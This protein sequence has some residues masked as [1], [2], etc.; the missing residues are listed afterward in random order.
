LCKGVK[1]ASIFFSK[2][3]FLVS[4]TMVSRLS[5][6]SFV[7][8]TYPA[9]SNRSIIPVNT[10]VTRVKKIIIV[11]RIGLHSS[12]QHYILFIV[13]IRAERGFRQISKIVRS[14]VQRVSVV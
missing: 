14:T 2:F 8:L 7:G 3:L 9:F 4:S 11:A 6:G 13:L 1:V 12:K 10:P 5:F